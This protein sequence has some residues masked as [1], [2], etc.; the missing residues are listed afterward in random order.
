MRKHLPRTEIESPLDKFAFAGG[1]LTTHSR[2]FASRLLSC[3]VARGGRNRASALFVCILFNN[4]YQIKCPTSSSMFMRILV[5]NPNLKPLHNS[6]HFAVFEST[7]MPY[8]KVTIFCQIKSHSSK[9]MFLADVKFISKC[10]YVA[11][12][13]PTVEQK[14]YAQ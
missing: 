2:P 12:N 3:V 9:M 14:K 8:L 13:F 5:L 4:I 7:K 6:P 11:K 10:I 1:K